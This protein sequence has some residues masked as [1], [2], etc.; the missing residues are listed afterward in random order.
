MSDWPQTL[1]HT[2]LCMPCGLCLRVA[3]TCNSLLVDCLHQATAH[4]M[5]PLPDSGHGI[6]QYPL[7]PG[8]MNK[9]AYLAF[10]C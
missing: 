8:M 6:Y 3:T 10:L 4:G 5:C 1:L 2:V 9:L 7:Y